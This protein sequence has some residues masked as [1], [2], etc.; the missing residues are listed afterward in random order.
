MKFMS[1]NVDESIF[2]KKEIVKMGKEYLS[3]CCIF[4]LGAIGYAVYER[5]LQATGKTMYSTISQIIGAL[6]NIV[7]DWILIYYTNL[8]VSG[9]AINLNNYIK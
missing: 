6:L 8:G 3:I 9:A 1:R 5:F 7:L 2:S 4:S